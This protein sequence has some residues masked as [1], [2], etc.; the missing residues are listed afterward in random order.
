MFPFSYRGTTYHGCVSKTN[1]KPWCGIKFSGCH[2][3]DWF[4]TTF[5]KK[6]HTKKFED[7]TKR[8]ECVQIPKMGNPIGVGSCANWDYC[9]NSDECT[10]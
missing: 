6:C 10:G 1:W 2:V 7:G 8:K 5:L 4:R 9:Q 3:E